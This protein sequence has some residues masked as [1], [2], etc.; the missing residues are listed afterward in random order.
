MMKMHRKKMTLKNTAIP[1]TSP[2]CPSYITDSREKP[3]KLSMTDKEGKMFQKALMMSRIDDNAT[4]A[5]F[6]ITSSDELGNNLNKVDLKN[7][8]FIH[9]TGANSLFLCKIIMPGR[10]PSIE[11]TLAIDD[12]LNTQAFYLEKHM[13]PLS[14]K[15]IN[16]GRQIE[17]IIYEID[18]FSLSLQVFTSDYLLKTRIGNAINEM[19]HAIDELDMIE[20][21][22]ALQF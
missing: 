22:D 18:V 20:D 16:D 3:N 4:V 13:I 14:I 2:N 12:D 10:T 15:K 7:G 1:T 17:T 9:N 8:W 6:L 11:K 19:K 21:N 5:K